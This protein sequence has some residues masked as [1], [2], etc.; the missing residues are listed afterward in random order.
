MGGVSH[1]VRGIQAFT[2]KQPLP[3]REAA[4]MRLEGIRVSASEDCRGQRS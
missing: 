2:I 4:G 1:L 3:D